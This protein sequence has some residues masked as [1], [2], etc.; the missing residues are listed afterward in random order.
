[1][2][3]ARSPIRSAL[4]QLKK[5]GVVHQQP[6]RGYFLAAPGPSLSKILNEF[7][8]A[9]EDPLYREI[10]ESRFRRKLADEVTEAELVRVFHTTYSKIHK[11]MAR[12]LQEGWVERRAGNGWSFLPIID[13]TDAL[14]ASNALRLMIEPAAILSPTFKVDPE[15]FEACKKHQEF[16]A[17]EGYSAMT[18]M[19]FWT[20]NARFH[21]TIAQW[22]GNRFVEQSVRRINQ[23]RR[24]LGYRNAEAIMKERLHRKAYH[25]EH[26]AILKHIE[27][28]EFRKA[29]DLMRKHIENGQRRMV[30]RGVFR[31]NFGDHPFP[32]PRRPGK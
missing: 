14:I 1:M 9:A 2:G 16:I 15:A 28:K 4:A 22:S 24:L 12:I 8:L 31:S 11:T 3:T 20:A 32:A 25:G 17:E 7:A 26:L 13:S 19:E 30:K 6:H 18:P 10:A 23:L 21:E 27:R 29:S 5:L